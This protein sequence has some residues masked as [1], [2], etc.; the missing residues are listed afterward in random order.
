MFNSEE[1]QFMAPKMAIEYR[2]EKG[3][4]TSGNFD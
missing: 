4:L 2:V 1:L 3:F